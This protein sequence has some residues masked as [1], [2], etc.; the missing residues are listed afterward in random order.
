MLGFGLITL[1]WLIQF[2]K[3]SQK[4]EKG[5]DFKFLV[6]YAVGAFALSYASF[7]AG[8]IIGGPLALATGILALGIGYMIQKDGTETKDNKEPEKLNLV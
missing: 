5:F 3:M 4:K 2:Y 1:G 6:V 8:D 7:S